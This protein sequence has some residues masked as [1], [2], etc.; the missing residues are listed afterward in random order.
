MKIPTSF[1]SKIESVFY[2]KTLTRH[3]VSNIKDD[4]GWDRQSISATGTFKGSVNYSKLNEVQEKYGIH[5]DIEA[6]V[7][8]SEEITLGEIISYDSR[9]FRVV[10]AVPFDSHNLLILEEWSSKSS[11]L[12]S[13]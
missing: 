6:T 11:T 12:I 2:D 4:E 10:K 8:T 9:L 13:A 3:D 1:K 7:H 5:T